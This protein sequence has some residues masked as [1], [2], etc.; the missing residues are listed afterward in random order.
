MKHHRLKMMLPQAEDT[1]LPIDTYPVV[2]SAVDTTLGLLEIVGVA[3]FAALGFA[4]SIVAA[5]V[6]QWAALGSGYAEAWES[7]RADRMN[8]GFA[9]GVMTATDGKSGHWVSHNF[10]ETRPE[11]GY[12]FV[13]GGTIA[14][15]AFNAG[16]LSGF[17]QGK[18]LTD[19]QKGLVW[20]DVLIRTG[21]IGTMKR[22]TFNSWG[23]GQWVG[24][25]RDM[26]IA[27]RRYHLT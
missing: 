3:E 23:H 12:D 8:M 26:G 5:V 10:G 22:D 15:K 24:W 21:K 2:I 20:Q 25:Y 19:Y 6:G 16:L 9:Y 4:T 1:N 11:D 18:E 17:Y 7:I 27:F 14:A 13:D